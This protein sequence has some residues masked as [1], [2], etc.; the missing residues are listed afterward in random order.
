MDERARV[1]EALHRWVS[2]GPGPS[3]DAVRDRNAL[4]DLC[5]SDAR[6]T[7]ELLLAHG[8]LV[9]Q[10]LAASAGAPWSQRREQSARVLVQ[11]GLRFDDAAWAVECWAYARG[12]IDA[13]ALT[14]GQAHAAPPA[15]SPVGR[16]S[17][18]VRQSAWA[19]R[20][21]GTGSARWRGGTPVSALP[22]WSRTDRLAGTALLLLFIAVTGGVWVGIGRTATEREALLAARAERAQAARVAAETSRLAAGAEGSAP[23]TAAS[24]LLLASPVGS[25]GG[26]G[27]T[28]TEAMPPTDAGDL[29]PL[30]ADDPRFAPPLLARGV[31]G[32]YVVWRA[33]VELS[34]DAGCA[35]LEQGLDWRRPT[36]EVIAHVPGH[37]TFAFSTR[38]TVRGQLGWDGRFTVTPVV[39]TADGGSYQFAMHGRFTDDGFEAESE[40]ISRVLVKWR[41]WRTCRLVATMRGVRREERVR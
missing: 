17:V 19:V 40:T 41:T 9:E 37:T 21:G 22:R 29:V 16:S 6:P 36:E 25:A 1:R 13:H 5:G 3:G 33:L 35:A 10:L 11:R 4:L 30:L 28:V 20:A 12:V 18:P 15:P 7:A 38:S 23:T 34:G 14:R 24:R 32:R 2:A 39:G 26:P 8:D 27:G 31:G